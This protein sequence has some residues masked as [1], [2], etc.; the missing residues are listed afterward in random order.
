MAKTPRWSYARAGVDRNDV[1]DSLA[2]L[3]AG[4]RYRPSPRSGRLL[5]LPGH[6]AGLVRIGSE[7]LAVTT[8][9]VGTK[10]V[11]AEELGSWEGVGEDV[12]QVNVNDLAAVGARPS[13]LVDC[14]LCARPDPKVF[15]AIGRGI[16]RGLKRAQVALAG[17]ETAVVPDIVRGTDLG[18]TAVGF[19]PGRRR[20][21]TGDRIRAGD[22]V[23][24]IPASGFHANGYTLLRKLLRARSV[25][26]RRPRPGARRP[27][28]E[29]LLRPGRIYVDASEAVAD[30][31][32]THG[33]AHISG[34]GVRNLVR[35]NPNVRF[36][37]DGWPSA[38]GVYRWVADLGEI[39][40][41]ELYQTFNLGIGFVAVV[42]ATAVDP[43]RRRLAAAG[44]RDSRVVG[45]VI[46]GEGVSLP[47]L[48]LEYHGY[49]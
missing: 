42:A 29:E 46:S 2:A 40:P 7:T 44:V 38:A 45:R 37:L 1:S 27:L 24:G 41:A 33:L 39:D 6:Y 14:I 23:L 32:T 35:L 43:T 9:T 26:V 15:A 8:D 48:G 11:L 21:V 18:G 30:L 34:G 10:V 13:V 20:P 3:L 28:G 31:S 17:G 47:H 16:G 49:A 25:D 5:D 12:V 19:F 4:T 36:E 22:V